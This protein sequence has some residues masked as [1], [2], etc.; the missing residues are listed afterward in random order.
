V[1]ILGWIVPALRFRQR[2][3]DF[4]NRFG[5]PPRADSS[6]QSTKQ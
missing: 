5:V 6:A 1:P 4:T 2:G 3:G